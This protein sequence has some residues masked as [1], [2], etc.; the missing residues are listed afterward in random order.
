ML[1]LLPLDDFFSGPVNL[2]L[3][4]FARVTGTGGVESTV[5][6][7][8]FSGSATLT[9]DFVEAPDVIAVPAPTSLPL[10]AAGL[11][12]FGFAARRRGR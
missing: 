11:A 8:S 6:Q 4:A 9:Y 2:P 7:N 10:F 3:F 12:V 1:E 5:L